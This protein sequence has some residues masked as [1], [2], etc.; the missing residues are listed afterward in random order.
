MKSVVYED[1]FEFELFLQYSYTLPQKYRLRLFQGR[2]E[3][4][5][6]AINYADKFDEGN[7]INLVYMLGYGPRIR[8][9]MEKTRSNLLV[10]CSDIPTELMAAYDE[11]IALKKKMIAW[12]MMDKEGNLTQSYLEEREKI[13]SRYGKG[14]GTPDFFTPYRMNYPE[15]DSVIEKYEDVKKD[16][17]K[18]FENYVLIERGKP[19]TVV[20]HSDI[21]RIIKRYFPY[22]A[23]AC[24][25]EERAYKNIF[26]K[27]RKAL[28][29]GLMKADC[30]DIL[31]FPLGSDSYKLCKKGIDDCVEKIK[32]ALETPGYI[33]LEKLYAEMKKPPYGW[34]DTPFSMYCFG[35]AMSN[36]IDGHWIYD[37]CSAWEAKE[38][39]KS[40]IK[41]TAGRIKKRTRP[42][43]T[44][45]CSSGESLIQK[46]SYTFGVPPVKPLHAMMLMVGKRIENHTRYPVSIIDKTLHE[47]FYHVER[48]MD[49]SVLEKWEE[50]FS[51]ER[52]DAIR[53]A[54]G[55]INDT[56]REQLRQRYPGIDLEDVE[57]YC[58]TA[59]SGWVWD[60][61][62]FWECVHNRYSGDKRR[63]GGIYGEIPGYSTSDAGGAAQKAAGGLTASA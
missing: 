6:K 24:G 33:S 57:K 23:E 44:L 51:K 7:V 50:H 20:K 14:D 54:Y 35:Y 36:F 21:D 22:G 47:L 39:A 34:N 42:I 55:R 37:T 41:Y 25:V 4:Y 26:E 31:G 3:H 40:A 9:Y 1:T 53:E 46:L 12:S 48:S 18:C 28:E 16:I 19:E 52:C 2:V 11:F 43:F 5:R 27:S 63:K 8:T 58:T 17:G 38:V 10:L 45:Y 30:S 61:D 56:V 15:Y 59:C 32:D 29:R 13:Y 49:K 62:T 60:A